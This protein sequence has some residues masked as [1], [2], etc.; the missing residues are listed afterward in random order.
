MSNI[1]DSIKSSE[2]A[3]QSLSFAILTFVVA[4]IIGLFVGFILQK[5]LHIGAAILGAI[6]GFFIGVAFYNIVFFSF[7]SQFLLTSCSILGSLIMAVLSFRQYDNIVIFGT[8]FIGSYTFTRGISF[9]I[10]NFPNEMVF[11]QNLI[12]GNVSATWET[13]FYLAV[14]VILFGLGVAYQR[15]QRAKDALFNYVRL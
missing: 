15:R 3:E 2:A 11:F 5:M 4:G 8:G 13:Y 9:F 12:E 10:G 7:K 14:F 6:G 1:L